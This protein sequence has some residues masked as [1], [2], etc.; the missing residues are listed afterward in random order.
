MRYILDVSGR[1]LDL[2]KAS[3]VHFERSL[4]MSNQA[5]FSHLT[6]ELNNIYLNLKRQKSKQLKAKLKRKWGVIS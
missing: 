5:D 3:I 4:D 1:D 6:D 2:I